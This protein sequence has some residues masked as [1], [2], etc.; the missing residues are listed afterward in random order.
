MVLETKKRNIIS[1]ALVFCITTILFFSGILSSLENGLLDLKFQWTKQRQASNEIVLVEIDT[2]SLQALPEWPWPRDFYSMLLQRLFENGVN[3][4]VIDID[5]SSS[6]TYDGDRLLAETL[7]N[8]GDNIALPIFKQNDTFAN[9][10]LTSSITKPLDIFL[11]HV[12]LAS[13]NVTPD[14]DGKIRKFDS[15]DNFGD[16]TIPSVAYYFARDLSNVPKS[17][18]IDYSID[19]SSIP[20]VSFI[21]IF[22]NKFDSSLI[23]GKHIIIGATALELKD[24]I[25][26]PVLNAIP[27]PLLHTLAYESISQDRM[28]FRTNSTFTVLILFIVVAITTP[29]LNR[30]QWKKGLFI[31]LTGGCAVIAA[32]TLTQNSF[33]V[34]IN[35]V[36]WIVGIL[37]TFFIETFSHIDMQTILVSSQRAQIHDQDTLMKSIVDNSFDGIFTITSNGLIKSIN[38]AGESMFKYHATEIIGKNISTIIPELCNSIID[39][40]YDNAVSLYCGTKEVTGIKSTNRNF[41]LELAITDLNTGNENIFIC[42]ARDITERKRQTA[43]LEH[44]ATHDEL[45][46]LPNRRLLRDRI[47][48]TLLVNKR[49]D[50]TLALL[51]MD[52]D[53]FKDINDTLG[54]HIGDKLLQEVAKRLSGLLRDSDTVARLGGDEFAVLLPEIANS[55]DIYTIAEKI[56]QSIETSFVIND[57]KLHVGISVGCVISPDHGEDVN[58]LL[59]RGDVAMYSAKRTNLH[60]ATYDF[61]QDNNSVRQLALRG[62][63][64]HAIENEELALYFQ[65]KINTRS[66]QISSVEVLVRWLH[67]EYGYM[68]PDEFIPMAEQTGLITPLTKWVLSR[69]IAQCAIWQNQGTQISVAVNLSAKDLMDSNLPATLNSIIKQNCVDPKMIV[70]EITES[71]IMDNPTR[72]LKTL[73]RLHDMGLKITID[74]FGTGYSSLAYIKKLP[75]DELKIDKSFVTS[76]ATNKSDYAIVRSTIELAHNLDLEVVAEGV[77]TE[78]TFDLLS[79]LGCDTA[80][81]YL[82]SKPVPQEDLIEWLSLSIWGINSELERIKNKSVNNL[83]DSA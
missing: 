61:S 67:P 30:Y 55:N 33:P 59:Q 3:D 18:Y 77:E 14:T 43:A 53:N 79:K 11:D 70:L 52:L 49:H 37:L 22:R 63:L 78:E 62:E 1:V 13:I 27:G 5:L 21:D 8:Y 35:C 4:V 40:G 9:D 76:M 39:E 73:N 47:N 81:G 58:T 42:A 82:F 72:A 46:Q 74:D 75:I 28:L 12:S 20:R 16:E 66:K 64:K 10:G 34:I 29:L 32:T 48:H 36:P 38:P 6:F 65:P 69:A 2:K 80:Q 68:P 23:K 83:A 45:T 56:V 24:I 26:A 51:V 44:N 7:A 60:Y 54:H 57:L 19:A 50:A 25:N 15:Y 71:H 41:P 31:C 17:F